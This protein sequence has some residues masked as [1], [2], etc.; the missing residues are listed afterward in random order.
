MPKS[1][2]QKP[3]TLFTAVV[4]SIDPRRVYLKDPNEVEFKAIKVTIPGPNGQE[5]AWY[6]CMVNGGWEEWPIGAYELAKAVEDLGAGE[7]LL[8]CIDCDVQGAGFD[9]NLMKFISDAVTI[10]VIASSG[11]GTVAHVSEFFMETNASTS[12]ALQA[13]S[14]GRRCLFTNGQASK[15][16]N[17]LQEN[18][19][20][21]TT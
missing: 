1:N 18:C 15:V 3:K 21:E 14:I 13:F 8:N 2:R 7:I 16:I 10:P 11:A 9:I 12:L 19:D 6:Q 20:C 4:V 17:I 5:Y